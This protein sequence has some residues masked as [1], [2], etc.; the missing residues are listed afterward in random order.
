[1]V[2]V[3]GFG[4]AVKMALDEVLVRIDVVYQTQHS[5]FTTISSCYDTDIEYTYN[6]FK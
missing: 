2:K 3:T 1:M 6:K 4:S 5:D